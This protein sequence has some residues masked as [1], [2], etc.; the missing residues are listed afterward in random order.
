MT[1]IRRSLPQIATVGTAIVLA[2]TAVTGAHGQDSDLSGVPRADCGPGSEPETAEQGRVPASDHESGR[3]DH[4]Y[5]CNTE[6]VGHHGST[7]GFKV[8]RY[9]DASGTECAYYDSTV[10]LPINVLNQASDGAGVIV[11]DMSDPANPVATTTLVT[12]AML[13]PHESLVLHEGR[14]LLAAVMG[15]AASYPGI[16]DIYDVSQDCTR[17]TLLSST[18]VGFLGHESGF[19]PDGMTFWSSSE[20]TAFVAAVDVSDPTL[21]VTLWVGT[22]PSHGIT[23]SEDGTRAYLTPVGTNATPPFPT[24]PDFRSGV[25]I[26]DVT[27]IQ[28]RRLDPQ[29]QVVSQLTW[30]EASIAQTAIPVSIDD[31]PYLVEIDEF[32]PVPDLFDT[33]GVPGAA[34]IIDIADETAPRVVSNIRL[35]VH[36]PQVREASGLRDD[37]NGSSGVLGYVGHYC[38]VP[39]REDPGIVACSFVASGL[40]VFDIRDPQNPR[41]IAYF[42]APPDPESFTGQGGTAFAMSAPAFVPERGEIWYSDVNSGFWAIRV[43]NDV[44]PFPADR[45]PTEGRARDESAPDAG[46]APVSRPSTPGTGNPLPA[47]AAAA[48]LLAMGVAARRASRRGTGPQRR[49]GP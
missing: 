42:N 47:G 13:S 12:P 4:P 28:E 23:I 21:P 20:A 25:T 35:E 8:H 44:W 33:D 32:V 3:A 6:I 5:T 29:P 15:T 27:D 34:R 30:P 49:G 38:A 43:T 14:G 9:V 36:D 16:V 11:L 39:R 24:G 37:P 10:L 17:P 22:N 2:G 45:S 26:L 18:P 40:R 1:S 19:S 41:E 48:V 46:P 31:H 7:G